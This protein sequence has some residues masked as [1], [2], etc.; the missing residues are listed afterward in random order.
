M[1]YA[2]FQDYL[3]S[4]SEEQYDTLIK[5]RIARLKPVQQTVALAREE[6]KKVRLKLIGKLSDPDPDVH[7]MVF[8]TLRDMDRSECEHGR[9]CCKYCS[10]CVEID[11]VMFPEL[12][13]ENG[14]ALD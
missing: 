5:E 8:D 6:Q 4:L 1:T 2:E 9:H 10:E 12:W 14:D 7:Q 11:H 13:D 3:L